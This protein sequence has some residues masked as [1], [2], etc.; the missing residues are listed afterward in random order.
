MDGRSDSPSSDS[1]LADI[2]L[3]GSRGTRHD[4]EPGRILDEALQSLRRHLGMEIAFISEFV[5]DQ[6][7]FRYV[8][9]DTA[10]A[11]IQPGESGPLDESY[12]Q[13]V[14]DGRLPELIH[15]ATKLPAA[16]DLAATMAFPVGAHLSVPVRFRDGSLYGTLCCFSTVPDQSLSQR[17]LN[18]MR[19]FADFTGR[20]LERDVIRQREFQTSLRRV[21]SVLDNQAFSMV[22]QPIVLL[23]EHRIVGYEALTRFSATPA[24]SPDKWFAEAAKV[25]LQ[26]KLELAAIDKALQVLDALPADTYL[27]FNVSP[28]TLWSEKLLP[29]LEPI[30]LNRIV[31]EVTE[32][33]SIPDYGKFKAVLAP[34][35]ER[36]VTLA[37][38]DA[39]AGYA[40]LRHILKLKP[41]IIKL[42]NS[43][44][45][46]I[47]T[48]PDSR[49]LAMALIQFAR[50]SGSK[51]IAEG[52]ETQ[53]QLDVLRQ[54]KVS[55]A[56]GYL[57]GHPMP[58]ER[59][60]TSLEKRPESNRF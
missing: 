16:L 55:K 19:V 41:D 1:L 43:L 54:L 28:D 33:V 22:F 14:I 31:L 27:S 59:L 15:D 17:D 6:R 9:S 2:I 38:D 32:H 10:P 8:D 20:Q 50:E 58:L 11:R 7:V 13:R 12:C 60:Q 18:M 46:N 3:P 53:S 49:A 30:A 42:D 26:A 23:R 47:D 24:R 36:G 35:R 51:I 52:V 45:S 44:T 40:S 29:M 21:Q 4:D 57:L 5:D 37:V 25:G 39:G 34:L 56:Q 48:D